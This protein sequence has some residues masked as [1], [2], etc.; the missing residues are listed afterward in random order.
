MMRKKFPYQ[1]YKNYLDCSR[2]IVE[3][4]LVQPANPKVV[5]DEGLGALVETEIVS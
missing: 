1:T 5:S 4:F 3:I 2:S